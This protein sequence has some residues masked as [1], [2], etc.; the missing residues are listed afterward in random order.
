MSKLHFIF[1][2]VA[3]NGRSLKACGLAENELK[4]RG[5]P[6]RIA[7]TERPGH[8]TIIA[9]NIAAGEDEARLSGLKLPEELV[10]RIAAYADATGESGNTTQS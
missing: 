7:R 5:L 10:R 1:N 9:Q 4:R 6:Y 2:P 3:G 8:A